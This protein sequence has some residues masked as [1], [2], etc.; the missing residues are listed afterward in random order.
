M[1]SAPC[2]ADTGRAGGVRADCVACPRLSVI[3][4]PHLRLVPFRNLCG[5]P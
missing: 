1:D 3:R 5:K 4:G 2:T